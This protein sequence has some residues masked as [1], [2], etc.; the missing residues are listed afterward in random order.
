MSVQIKFIK[1]ILFYRKY[2]YF[3]YRKYSVLMP[4]YTYRKGRFEISISYQTEV[5][6]LYLLFVRHVP[7]G[8][9]GK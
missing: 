1:F 6:D 3:T 8:V 7:E 5:N 2:T 9:D 4:W